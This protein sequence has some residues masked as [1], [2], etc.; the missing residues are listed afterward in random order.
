[1]SQY[2][3]E[4]IGLMCNQFLG[5]DAFSGTNIYDRLKLGIQPEIGNMVLPHPSRKTIIEG[6]L[7]YASN[8]FSNCEDPT[9][10]KFIHEGV[11]LMSHFESLY[12]LF[13]VT[14]GAEIFADRNP[15]VG[16]RRDSMPIPFN[17]ENGILISG[18]KMRENEKII[19]DEYQDMCRKGKDSFNR[20][21]AINMNDFETTNKAIMLNFMEDVIAFAEKYK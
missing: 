19:S 9:K 1:M 10:I 16:G 17:P 6:F 14:D 5:R 21:Y 2:K 7:N 4:D 13:Q 15:D 3:K 11:S 8:Y 12:H 20:G 18:K